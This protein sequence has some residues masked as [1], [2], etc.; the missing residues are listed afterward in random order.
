MTIPAL[1]TAG[2]VILLGAIG[3]LLLG[4]W[5]DILSLG[6][7]VAASLGLPVELCRGLSLTLAAALSAGA[8]CIA[9]LLSFLGLIVPHILRRLIGSDDHR[10]LA[11]LTMLMGSCLTLLCDIA[12][13]M[14]FRP[15]EIP[16]GIL[17]AVLGVPFFLH[18]LYKQG[19]RRRT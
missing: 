7:E 2:P 14:L 17:L 18:L 8:V 16:V 15:Y 10:R 9:G 1:T 12:A 4:R 11:A 19:R 13:R 6:D 5:L 3:L